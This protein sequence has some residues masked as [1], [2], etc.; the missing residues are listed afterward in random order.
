[1]HFFKKIIERSQFKRCRNLSAMNILIFF[2]YVKLAKN[3]VNEKTLLE[4]IEIEKNIYEKT[5]DI[6]AKKKEISKKQKQIEEIERQKQE[7]L[8]IK[9]END[10]I[11]SSLKKEQDLIINQR[12]HFLITHTENIRNFELEKININ[13]KTNISQSDKKVMSDKIDK[14]LAQMKSKAT[15]KNYNSE[16]M[17]DNKERKIDDLK[18]TIKRIEKIIEECEKT[19][20]A[21]RGSLSDLKNEESNMCRNLTDLKTR[22]TQTACKLKY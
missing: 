20:S 4:L 17:Y 12:N 18:Q 21:M 15:S 5:K 22:K 14:N 10:S 8:R 3:S 11:I 13:L 2:L 7:M 16:I 6:E 1:M 19:I 9:K